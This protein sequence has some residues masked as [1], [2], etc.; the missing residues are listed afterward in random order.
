MALPLATVLSRDGGVLFFL[1]PPPRL[2]TT[3]LEEPSLGPSFRYTAIDSSQ[4]HDK[5]IVDAAVMIPGT[6]AR[7]IRRKRENAPVKYTFAVSISELL[8]AL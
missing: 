4:R 1:F 5:I 8:S 6:R 2:D 7:E 3:L